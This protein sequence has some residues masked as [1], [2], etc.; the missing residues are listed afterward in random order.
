MGLHPR[1]E[2]RP[3]RH[4]HEGDGQVEHRPRE[5]R[6]HRLAV[7]LRRHVA[8][9]VG[10][11]DAEVL[12][13][14]EHPVG[15]GHP[16]RL[17]PPVAEREVAERKLAGVERRRHP[18]AEA[19]RQRE[20]DDRERE[21]RA[22]DEHDRLHDVG[23]HHRVEP[24][25]HRVEHRGDAHDADHE[26]HVHPEERVE[27]ERQQVEDHPAPDRLHDQEAPARVEPRPRAEARLEEG[28]RR[29]ARLAAVERHEPHRRRAGRERD[30]ERE[31]ERVPVREVRLGR[32]R[33]EGDGAD[34]GREHRERERPARQPA[35][36]LGELVGPVPAPAEV[37]AASEE[38]GGDEVDE[39]YGD[40]DIHRRQ[41][42]RAES[43]A[44]RNPSIIALVSFRTPR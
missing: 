38:R 9:G 34:V 24:A 22:G 2:E 21:E 14:E 31:D 11:V 43:M 12:E 40:V 3:D 44:R 30:R 27:D 39:D 23:P 1:P 37:E 7:G 20:G 19:V 16:E 15:E 17:A 26:R 4:E 6:P 36:G 33:E 10:L 13:V 18:G 25:H 32:Q 42:P 8:L 29:G 5:H 41:P 28:V 35:A